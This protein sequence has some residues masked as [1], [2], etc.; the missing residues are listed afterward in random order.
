[1]LLGWVGHVKL[2][3][4]SLCHLQL[5]RYSLAGISKWL[6]FRRCSCAYITQLVVYLPA[7]TTYAVDTPRFDIFSSGVIPR[8]FFEMAKSF[9]AERRF[10]GTP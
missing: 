9:Q 10:N 8:M 5:E 6:F 7:V 3:V 2:G 1:V 4:G